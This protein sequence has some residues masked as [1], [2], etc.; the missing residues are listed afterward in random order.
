[1]TLT[2]LVEHRERGSSHVH[3]ADIFHNASKEPNPPEPFLS[4][5]LIEPI[6]KE[7]YP[8]RALLEANSH[9]PTV[10]PTTVE[11]YLLSAHYVNI[12]IA[13]DFGNNVNENGEN[14]G[15]VALFNNFTKPI[16]QVKT[17]G[18][19]K[20]N[21]SIEET[22]LDSVNKTTRHGRVIS[23]E[24]D[25]ITLNEIFSLMRKSRNISDEHPALSSGMSEFR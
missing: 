8:L 18:V 23:H 1:M 3:L 6:S 15:I 11:P 20:T 4:K 13:M 25:L 14:S 22:N 10:K 12:P 5:S 9:D 21:K 24:Q 7:T 19:V 17:N 16:E 2:E